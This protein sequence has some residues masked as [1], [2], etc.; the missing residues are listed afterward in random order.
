M[1][2]KITR[3]SSLEDNSRQLFKFDMTVS[4]VNCDEQGPSL[5]PQEHLQ[6]SCKNFLTLA[7]ISVSFSECSKPFRLLLPSFFE[8]IHATLESCCKQM[9]V[10]MTKHCA[11]FPGH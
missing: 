10:A 6:P 11:H 2:A 5:G 9:L 7:D 3:S 4:S 1:F 8:S